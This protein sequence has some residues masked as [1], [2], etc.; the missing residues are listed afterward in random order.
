M[1]ASVQQLDDLHTEV[2]IALTE[3]IKKVHEDA[4]GNKLRSA[5]MLNAAIKFLANNSI[6]ATQ[7]KPALKKLV[8][9][10]PTFDDDIP[11]AST[12]AAH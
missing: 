11:F 9:A 3:E 5:P 1:T 8:D 4:N 12:G 6:Q 7:D 10:L 2:C